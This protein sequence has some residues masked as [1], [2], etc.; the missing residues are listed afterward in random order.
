MLVTNR[1]GVAASSSSRV[2][3]TV[4]GLAASTF[5]LMKTRPVVVAAHAVDVSAVVRST[6]ATAGP[7]RS[8]QKASVNRLGPSSA[9]SPQSSGTVAS[10]ALHSVLACSIDRLPKPKVLV[11]YAV[12]PVPANIVPLT[13]GSLIT[14]V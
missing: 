6:A 9:Q 12:S 2:H 10:H 3:P 11:R 7:A 4:A 13:F 1:F 8:P 5:L 14:G